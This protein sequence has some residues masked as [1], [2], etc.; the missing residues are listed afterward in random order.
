MR[1]EDLKKV[2]HWKV[3]QGGRKKKGNQKGVTQK[4]KQKTRV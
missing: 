3:D 4:M 1:G 2:V